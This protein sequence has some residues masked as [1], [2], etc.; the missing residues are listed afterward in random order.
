MKVKKIIIENFRGY[1]NRTTIDLD[2]FTVFI[3]K[4]DAGKSTIL[5]ALDIYFG[6]SNPD[7]GDA[8]VSG[9][10]TKVRIGCVFTNFPKE[11]VIDS[12]NPTTLEKEYLLNIDGDLEIHKIYNCTAVKPKCN[13]AVAIANHPSESSCSNLLEQSIGKLKTIAKKLKIDL[14]D[15]DQTKKA[16]LREAIRESVDDLDLSITEVPLLKKVDGQAIFDNLENT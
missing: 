8:C 11:L 7:P 10:A 15:V 2:D 14:S 4:N 1:K 9:D 3:G 16:D 12:S 6:N 5:E 13:S